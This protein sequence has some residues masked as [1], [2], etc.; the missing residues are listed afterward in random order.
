MCW[1]YVWLGFG[2]GLLA[3]VWWGFGSR[4]GGC[5]YGPYKNLRESSPRPP[6]LPHSKLASSLAKAGPIRTSVINFFKEGKP[7]QPCPFLLRAPFCFEGS[8]TERETT[9]WTPRLERKEAW[10]H[11]REAFSLWPMMRW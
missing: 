2:S 9:L 5:W 6:A 3:C 10:G 11:F 8:R 1:V 7:V 4:G